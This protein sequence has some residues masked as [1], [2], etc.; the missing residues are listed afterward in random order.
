MGL[1][2]IIDEDVVLPVGPDD[3]WDFFLSPR[4]YETFTGYGPIPGID[5]LEWQRG[6]NLEPGSMALVHSKDG[7]THHEHVVRVERP[8]HYEIRIDNFSSAFRLLVSGGIEIAK[9]SPVSGGTRLD[10]RFVFTLKSALGWPPGLV[11]RGLFRRAVQRNHANMVAA[12][13]G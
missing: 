11:V 6:S 13:R 3:A 10:R 5:R 4:G 1:E 2:L 12:L 7:S 9:F 8:A